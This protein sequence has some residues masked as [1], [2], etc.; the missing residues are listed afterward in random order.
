MNLIMILRAGQNI[1][2]IHQ[3]SKKK[4]ETRVVD[5]TTFDEELTKI[6]QTEEVVA[7]ENPPE[8]T[9]GEYDEMDNLEFG[10]EYLQ[11]MKWRQFRLARLMALVS[12]P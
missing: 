4:E 11:F 8:Q 3:Q 6:I 7:L 1:P 2:M 12:W 9:E 5:Q 10:S